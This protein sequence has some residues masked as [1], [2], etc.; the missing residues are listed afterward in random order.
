MDVNKVFASVAYL[1]L[2]ICSILDI[3]EDYGVL[4][5]LCQISWRNTCMIALLALPS[6]VWAS[7]TFAVAC[8][9]CPSYGTKLIGTTSTRSEADKLKSTHLKARP[10]HNVKIQ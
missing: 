5:Y 2:K 4:M 3:D 6:A 1:M 9:S 8:H 7:T 10:G